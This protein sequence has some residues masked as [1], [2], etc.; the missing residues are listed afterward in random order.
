MRKG[1][2]TEW[3]FH[4][5]VDSVQC[6]PRFQLFSRDALRR[7]QPSCRGGSWSAL[8]HPW[9]VGDHLPYSCPGRGVW[10]IEHWLCSEC[11]LSPPGGDQPA[12]RRH[13]CFLRQALSCGPSSGQWHWFGWQLATVRSTANLGTKQMLLTRVVLKLVDFLMKEFTQSSVFFSDL[14]SW[15]WFQV[16]LYLTQELVGFPKFKMLYCFLSTWLLF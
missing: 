3:L 7:H 15:Y 16:C 6:F 5:A 2:A 4:T 8:A 13:I 14:E 10:C 12:V 9:Q 11:V 1:L